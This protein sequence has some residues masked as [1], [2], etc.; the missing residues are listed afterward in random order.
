MSYIYNI[1]LA[2]ANPSPTITFT[3]KE[4]VIDNAIE[5]YNNRTYQMQNPKKI[6]KISLEKS[7]LSIKLES[8][9]PLNSLGRALRTFST[10][11]IKE[12]KDPEFIAQ[13]TSNGQLFSTV[14]SSEN[15]SEDVSNIKIDVND[16]DDLEIV[17]ALLDYIY[18]KRDSNS[19][20]YRQK[21]AAMNKIKQIVVDSGIYIKK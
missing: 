20:V 11:I 15:T 16:I 21:K 18:K 2:F 1:Q 19:T 17:K 6:E 9:L 5:D 7:V 3:D 13:I 4:D 8:A 14:H 10:I 12:Y